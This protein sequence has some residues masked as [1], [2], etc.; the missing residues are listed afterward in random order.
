MKLDTYLKGND[1]PG[2]GIVVGRS[3][4][5][6]SAVIAYFIMGRSENSRN[7]I[8][9][10]EDGVLKT[11]LFDVS[12]ITNEE[13]IIYSALRI[14]ESKTIVSNG[15][16]TDTIYDYLLLGKSLKD[17]VGSRTYEPDAP[18]F[19]PRIA[20]VIDTATEPYF[21]MS[22]IKKSEGSDEAERETYCYSDLTPGVARI[23]HTYGQSGKVLKPFYGAPKEVE[24]QGGLYEFST[25]LWE[26]LNSENKISLFTRFINLKTNEVTSR[27][28]NK[29]KKVN[30]I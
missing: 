12:R 14:L 21:E 22:I 20:A 7:R 11:K 13:L 25:N 1:Y 4:D 30:T 9:V 15:D 27:I 2:R 16:H 3:S 5:G 26:S 10:Q 29:N 23:I 24:I 18:N 6:G 17:A 8:F 19:T 28:I